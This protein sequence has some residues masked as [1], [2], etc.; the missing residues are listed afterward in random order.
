MGQVLREAQ[1]GDVVTMSL[2]DGWG[3]PLINNRQH[4]DNISR[5]VNAGVVVVISASNRGLD[6]SHPESGFIDHGD[7]G[8]FIVGACYP[9]NG[10]RLGFSNYN[11]RNMVNAWG[12]WV[13]TCGYGTLFDPG[14]PNRSYTYNYS[15]T[16]A[17]APMVAGVL[18]L[19]Q[20][21][22]KNRYHRILNNRQMLS[23]INATGGREGVQDGIGV[24]P[25]AAQAIAYIDCLLGESITIRDAK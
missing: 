3:L 5:M 16:S 7:S 8:A 18:T 13:A 21:H 11:V 24:R 12:Q 1:P 14:T 25:N 9:I 20:S 22:A 6:L 17:A 10:R 4:W 15:G 19:L 2:H 23:I